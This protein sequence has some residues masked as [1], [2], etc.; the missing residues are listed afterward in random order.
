MSELESKPKSTEPEAGKEKPK[1]ADK[2]KDEDA[3]EQLV[4]LSL[5]FFAFILLF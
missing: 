3:P 4:R 5:S 1:D 2:G